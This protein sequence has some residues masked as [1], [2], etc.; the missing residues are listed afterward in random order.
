MYDVPTKQITISNPTEKINLTAKDD[1]SKVSAYTTTGKLIGSFEFFCIDEEV[2]N[3]RKMFL[4]EIEGYQRRGIGRS[5]LEW[6]K[7]DSGM[8]IIASEDTGQQY[9]DGS[10]LTGTGLPFANKMMDLGII[11]DHR[12]KYDPNESY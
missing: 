11:C 6:V 7:N 2:L 12:D 5:I 10:H 1:F 3:L 4:E 8:P 9:D